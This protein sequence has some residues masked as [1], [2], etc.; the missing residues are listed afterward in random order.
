MSALD[1]LLDNSIDDLKDLP[2]FKCY[3]SGAHRVMFKWEEKEVNDVPYIIFNFKA[4]ETVELA[5]AVADQPLEAGSESSVMFNLS[6]EFGQGKFKK[7]VAQLAKHYGTSSPRETLEAVQGAEL[8][9]VTKVRQ[10][11]DKTQSYTDLDS[12]II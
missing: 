9:I 6:N 10:N 11:K 5:D 7:A 12:F 1:S 4:L 2:E 8:T 3:P